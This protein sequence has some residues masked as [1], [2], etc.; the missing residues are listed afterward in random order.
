MLM[1]GL[2]L[3]LVLLSSCSELEGPASGDGAAS[4]YTLE[5]RA[6]DE[7]Q[8]FR[9]IA[10][11]GRSAAGRVT[12]GASTLMS[13]TEVRSLATAAAPASGEAQRGGVSLQ[14][15]G[16]SL[17]VSGQGDERSGEGSGRVAIETGDRS[18]VVNASGNDADGDGRAH[19]LIQGADEAEARDFIAKAERLSPAVQAAML[20]ELGLD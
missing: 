7:E 11:D 20:S 2:F 14:L 10:P 17:S 5:V 1:R 16:L 19:V 15:P 9:V 4:G 13:E 18:V 3:T 8:V 6:S 12:G